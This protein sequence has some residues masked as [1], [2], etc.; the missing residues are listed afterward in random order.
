MQDEI[1][2][3]HE[4]RK[5]IFLLFFCLLF[6]VIISYLMINS[7]TNKVIASI[8][9]ARIEYRPMVNNLNASAGE[10]G[11][12]VKQ[13]AQSGTI[14]IEQFTEQ[15]PKAISKSINVVQNEYAISQGAVVGEY[16]GLK[17]V[18]D[19]EYQQLKQ[20]LTLLKKD[21]RAD[22]VW[23][24]TELAQ[25]RILIAWISFAFGLILTLMSIQDILE[26]LRWFISFIK[27]MFTRRQEKAST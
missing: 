23:V 14:A 21:M 12:G 13:I 26:N 8:E 27:K 2:L 24:K 19:L 9:D 1:A 3:I 17:S 16:Q 11:A 25:W 7:I 18:V 5:N 22:I 15:L 20:E 6:I 4:K 10:A